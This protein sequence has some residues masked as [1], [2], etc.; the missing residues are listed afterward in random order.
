MAFKSI[1]LFIYHTKEV[2]ENFE[3][4]STHMYVIAYRAFTGG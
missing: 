1:A 4:I 3:T 2:N